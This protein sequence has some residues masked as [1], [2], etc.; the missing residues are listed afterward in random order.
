MKT[1]SADHQNLGGLIDGPR[2]GRAPPRVRRRLTGSPDRRPPRHRKHPPLPA[3]R[4][5]KVS[6]AAALGRA[7]LALFGPGDKVCLS[8][9]P[10]RATKF[11]VQGKPLS[12][13]CE[14]EDLPGGCLLR[15]T[16]QADVAAIADME[17]AFLL[18]T[19]ARPGLA[20]VDLSQMSFIS[21]D[22]I[23]ALLNLRKALARH[24]GSVRC[25]A[26]QPMVAEAF[27]R[28]RLYDVL[29]I[30]DTLESALESNPG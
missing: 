30:H 12:F 3:C 5:V 25:A 24:G 7:T 23:G 11:R 18:R 2:P 17:L 21:S 28:V 6:R 19:A 26:P 29:D 22:G 16:G 14:A 20:V 13:A 1:P 4:T 10:R 9:K 27:R 15:M 8:G